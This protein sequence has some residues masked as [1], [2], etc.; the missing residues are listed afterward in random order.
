MSKSLGE[1]KL[2]R[3][4]G[5]ADVSCSDPA[6]AQDC[7]F[8]CD[9]A[10]NATLTTLETI[11]GGELFDDLAWQTIKSNVPIYRRFDTELEK[12]RSSGVDA[13]TKEEAE[14]KIKE[15]SE[16]NTNGDHA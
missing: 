12:E 15:D 6:R 1:N 11:Y 2:K 3:G 13:K 10:A 16:A 5:R 8:L 4:R 7:E 9:E 14:P